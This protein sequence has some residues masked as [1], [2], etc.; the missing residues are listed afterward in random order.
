[1]YTS[2]TVVLPVMYDNEVKNEKKRKR[3]NVKSI[4]K[5]IFKKIS[6]TLSNTIAI[7]NVPIVSILAA[8]TGMP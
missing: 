3:S 2:E 4:V 8:M 5:K 1:M 7:S 6:L